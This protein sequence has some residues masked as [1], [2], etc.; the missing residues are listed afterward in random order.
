[1]LVVMGDIYPPDKYPGKY[2]VFIG[3]FPEGLKNTKKLGIYGYFRNHWFF[4]EFSSFEMYFVENVHEFNTVAL[5][6]LSEH[7]SHQLRQLK[8]HRKY[9]SLVTTHYINCRQTKQRAIEITQIL[10]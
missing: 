1:M 10:L 5:N 2:R 9:L 4:N 7:Y 6:V 3:Y 8:C